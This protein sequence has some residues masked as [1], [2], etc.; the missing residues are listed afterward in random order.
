MNRIPQ[1]LRKKMS[2]D[3]YYKVCCITGLR[4]SAGDPIEWHHN[5][6]FAGKQVQARFAILPIKRTFH[7]NINRTHIK[8]KIDWIMLNRASEEEL[9]Q[10]SKA[11][12]LGRRRSELNAKFGVYKEPLGGEGGIAY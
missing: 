11:V 12:D 9:R 10:Y 3:P 2:A 4:Q 7:L 8:E 1:S 6:I 5:L